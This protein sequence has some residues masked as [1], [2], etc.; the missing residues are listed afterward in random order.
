MRPFPPD[1]LE[2]SAPDGALAVLRVLR[3]R[4]LDARRRVEAREDAEALHD[5]RV[6]LR[7]LRSCLRAYRPLLRGALPDRLR[8]Q[9]GGIAA[10][11]G[12]GRDAEVQ[13][14]WIE[15]VTP[16]LTP[17]ERPGAEHFAVLLA[18]RLAAH[19]A[20]AQEHVQRFDRFQRSLR[21]RLRTATQ[22]LSGHADGLGPRTFAAATGALALE[23][24]AE[25]G[26]R[27]AEVAWVGNEEEAHRARISAKR[28]R[29]L[30]EPVAVF[31]P[32][33][34][35]VVLRLR[36][37]QDLLGDLHDMHVAAA[38]IALLRMDLEG[39]RIPAAA[40][41]RKPRARSLRH[42]RAEPGLAALL[43]KATARQRDLFATLE[44]EW[45]GSALEEF[46]AKAEEVGKGL[47][48]AGGLPL[49][50]ERKYLLTGLPA[51]LRGATAL[52]VHQ[53]WL[54]GTVLRERI[55]R[56]TDGGRDRY[57][58]TVKLGMGVERIEIE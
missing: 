46:L 5:F 53:G 36:T 14:Q 31:R 18:D 43:R 57:Y 50:I 8:R 4:A 44:R 2:L 23:K 40:A 7:R 33:A 22:E 38:A 55:R 52:E 47:V 13:L 51:A 9:L 12:G 37:L 25:L 16:T 1:V 39:G 45:L 19:R 10:A 30:L 41:P 6:A 17:A 11:T 15:S 29:Y 3:R 58:R 54:P 21:G 28:L 26:A 49:E 34:D 56:L 35:A 48:A 42:D 24:T 27:L 32:D 20:E